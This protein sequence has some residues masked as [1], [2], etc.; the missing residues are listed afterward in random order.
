DEP[1]QHPISEPV[2]RAVSSTI[3]GRTRAVDHVE[4]IRDQVT[5][6]PGRAGG[7]V[8]SVAIDHDVYIRLYVGEHPSH[9]VALADERL[10]EYPRA[11]V[12]GYLSGLIGRA[13]VVHINDGRRQVAP[14]VVHDLCDG[15]F[16]VAAGDQHGDSAAREAQGLMIHGLCSAFRLA[17]HG[18]G[19]TRYLAFIPCLM[20]TRL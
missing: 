12:A 5:D 19:A 6:Q 16:L 14:E 15:G 17:G 3:R 2:T 18:K 10:A 1:R 9:H 13:I 8:R 7:I 11:R 20:S 4:A